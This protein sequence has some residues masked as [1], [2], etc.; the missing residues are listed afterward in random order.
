MTQTESGA[1]NRPDIFVIGSMKGGTTAIHHILTQHPDIC[2]GSAKE[3]HYF[4]LHYAKGEDWYHGHFAD[5]PPGKHYV[6]ASPTYFD[7]ANTP[8][9]PRLLDAYAPDCRPI[10]I[11]RNPIER[12]ISHFHHLQKVNRLAPLMAMNADEFFGMN[13]ARAVS[14]IGPHAFS[15][16]QAL[17]FSFYFQRARQYEQIFGKRLLVL[18]NAQLREDAKATVAR[19]FTHVGVDPI[20][21][22]GFTEIRHSHSTALTDVSPDTFARL[23]RLF[24]PDYEL[25]C[26]HFDLPMQWPAQDG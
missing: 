5:C 11:V 20:W 3:L 10:L 9:I 12:A 6:D 24:R 17:D 19:L 15:L 4:S 18:E 25:F 8:L 7:A 1:P 13:L 26:R 14:R 22:D 2:A 21:D 16:M 23:A